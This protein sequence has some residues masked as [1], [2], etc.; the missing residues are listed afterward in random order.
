MNELQNFSITS[1]VLSTVAFFVAR[2]YVTRQLEEWGIPGSTT[3]S[4]SVFVAAA[5]LS[6]AVGYVVDWMVLPHPA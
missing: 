1:L 3:R 5:A 6:Y 2:H 4:I